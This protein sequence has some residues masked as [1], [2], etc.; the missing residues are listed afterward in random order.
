MFE[1][2]WVFTAVQVTSHSEWLDVTLGC[3]KR[4]DMSFGS[5]RYEAGLPFPHVMRV[6]YATCWLVA[7]SLRV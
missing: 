4:T 5:R 3:P 7:G 2:R 1:R 6:V